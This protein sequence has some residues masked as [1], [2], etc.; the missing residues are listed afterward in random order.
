MMS[1][2]CNRHVIFFR[3]N[4]QGNVEILRILHQRTDI[5]PHV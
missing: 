2:P 3:R 1:C 5:P 4:R